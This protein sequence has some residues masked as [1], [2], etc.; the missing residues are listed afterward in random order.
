MCLA[1]PLKVRLVQGKEGEGKDFNGGEGKR[2]GEVFKLNKNMF[3]S[4]D[5]RK[6]RG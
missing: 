5:E 3:G 6:W 2:G 1:G 4:H